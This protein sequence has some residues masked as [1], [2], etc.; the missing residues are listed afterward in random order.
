MI[1]AFRYVL[2]QLYAGGLLTDAY[3]NWREKLSRR[4]GLRHSM[5]TWE[6]KIRTLQHKSRLRSAHR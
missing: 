2:L 5:A 1:L 6:K 3:R 4:S